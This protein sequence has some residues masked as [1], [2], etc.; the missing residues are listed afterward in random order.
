MTNG[1]FRFKEHKYIHVCVSTTP[2]VLL[3]H[4]YMQDETQVHACAHDARETQVC[5]ASLALRALIVNMSFAH[6]STCLSNTDVV[7]C[8]WLHPLLL[9]EGLAL[10]ACL[11]GPLADILPLEACYKLPCTSRQAA[12][13]TR[14]KIK[15]VP[16]LDP[17]PLTS[18][19]TRHRSKVLEKTQGQGSGLRQTS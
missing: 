11:L 5:A 2:H 1:K 13:L 4:H 9:T 12:S 16:K 19:K 17:R 18:Y 6:A 14:C 7:D 8:S 15:Q 10:L 3:Q